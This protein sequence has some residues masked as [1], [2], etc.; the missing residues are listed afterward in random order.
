MDFLLFPRSH[1]KLVFQG[2]SHGILHKPSVSYTIY[3]YG[4]LLVCIYKFTTFFHA[5][6]C[7]YYNVCVVIVVAVRGSHL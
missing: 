6:T 1:G 7:M 2:K 3:G 4:N 5:L